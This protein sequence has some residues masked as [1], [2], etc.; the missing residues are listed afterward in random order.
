MS[1]TFDLGAEVSA[2]T[3]QQQAAIRLGRA[4]MA[5]EVAELLYP[6]KNDPLG[7]FLPVLRSLCELCE[8]EAA[9]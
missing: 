2:A 5:M 9:K 6:L 7:N 8:K 1:A 3:A 4:Q